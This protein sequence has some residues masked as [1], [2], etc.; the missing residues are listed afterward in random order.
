MT[1]Y[2]KVKAWRAAKP[3]IRE[4]RAREAREWRSAH[5]EV[6]K[7]IKERYRMKHRERLLPIEAERARRRRGADPEGNR[8]RTQVF[9]ERKRVRQETIAGRPRPTCCE[10]CKEDAVTKF[11]HDHAT[12][13]FRGWLCDRCNRTLGQVKD[14]R[15]LL[16]K[17]IEYLG[18]S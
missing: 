10:L 3:N 13:K 8:R 18:R 12:G 2:E 9:L 1:A 11:D 17:M 16:A 5:P 14:S 6:A 7:A 15:E 4:I